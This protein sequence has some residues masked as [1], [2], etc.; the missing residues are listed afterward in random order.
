MVQGRPEV[1]GNHVLS[2][3][4]GW[5]AGLTS[6]LYE[7]ALAKTRLHSLSISMVRLTEFTLT[8]LLVL[9]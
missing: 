2:P 4:R 7:G 1:S 9:G 6:I 8:A 3:H 5:S